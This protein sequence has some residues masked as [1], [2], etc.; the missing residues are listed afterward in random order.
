MAWFSSSDK[1]KKLED[2]VAKNTQDL[3]DLSETLSG[4]RSIPIENLKKMEDLMLLVGGRFSDREGKTVSLQQI[5][6][7]Y[8]HHEN[9]IFPF[10]E[11]I[12]PGFTKDDKMIFSTQVISKIHKIIGKGITKNGEIVSFDEII[13]TFKDKTEE[14]KDKMYD[15]F[16]ICLIKWK[17]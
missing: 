13:C 3:I 17:K 1:I 11:I 16:W 2:Q 6:G 15:G 5:I 7:G 9:K 10:T 8:Y 14:F 4:K 12:G